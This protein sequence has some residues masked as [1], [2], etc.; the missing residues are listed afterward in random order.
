[1][2]HACGNISSSFENTLQHLHSVL[3]QCESESNASSSKATSEAMQESTAG[4]WPRPTYSPFVML[5]REQETE[6]GCSAA[7]MLE[8]TFALNVVFEL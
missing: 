5:A 3:G 2:C 7:D 8:P 6:P 4:M 1:M